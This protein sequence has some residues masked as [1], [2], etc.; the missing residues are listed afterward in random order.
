MSP[1]AARGATA[2]LHR[3]LE[4]DFGVLAPPVALLTPAP[5]CAAATWVALRES[6]LVAGRTS[7]STR[8]AVATAVSRDNTCPYCVEVHGS[9][10]GSLDP[11]DD[12]RDPRAWSTADPVERAELGAV[13]L[14][15]EHI[16]RLVNV[17]L[18]DSPLPDF[19]PAAVRGT[20]RRATGAVIAAD[21][22]SP[23]PGASLELLPEPARRAPVPDDLGWAVADPRIQQAL[24][25]A[26][27][28]IDEAGAR[29]LPDTV[30][31]LLHRHLAEHGTG[32]AGVSR[33]WAR[34]AVRD[35]PV[36]DR[37][38]GHL[39]LLTARASYQVGDDTVAACRE[40]G[41]DDAALVRAV[42]WA[43]MTA[44]RHTVRTASAR[45]SRTPPENE[46]NQP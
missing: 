39:T 37:P 19:A 43:A 15:F 44:A 18:P 11:A 23:V 33:S 5:E 26:V 42:S 24:T 21:R 8:E 29:T 31:G 22:G 34:T 41:A 14:T 2:A 40:A 12:A 17:F 7:R 9:T 38:L 35:L 45:T 32:P 1:R 25:A 16:N 3:Q 46:R 27:S 28:A 4:R 30:R 20:L 6:L 13:T 10:L 36:A